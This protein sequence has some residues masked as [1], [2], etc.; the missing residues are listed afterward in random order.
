MILILR[1]NLKVVM[2][3][4]RENVVHQTVL[5]QLDWLSHS[6]SNLLIVDPEGWRTV[7]DL[8]PTPLNLCAE[9]SNLGEIEPIL[10]LPLKTIT[11]DAI[12]LYKPNTGNIHS[13]SE[14]FIFH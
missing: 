1:C 7:T 12:S 10:M 6:Y 13:T 9:Y 3:F 8:P 11:S 4:K 2:F 14:N 5:V